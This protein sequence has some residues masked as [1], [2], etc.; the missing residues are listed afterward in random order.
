MTLILLSGC[1]KWLDNEFFP[2]PESLYPA[3]AE[4]DT[5]FYKSIITEDIDT[6]VVTDFVLDTV[7]NG[8]ILFERTAA[9]FGEI[10]ADTVGEDFFYISNETEKAV[11]WW[12]SAYVNLSSSSVPLDTTIQGYTYSDLMVASALRQDTTSERLHRIYFDWDYGL[13]KFE[14]NNFD[15]YELF[16]RPE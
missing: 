15:I 10:V 7:F 9:I 6:F 5:F 2:L 12:D 11:F 3:Y 1:N 14:Y 16:S 13:V 4:G 8:S